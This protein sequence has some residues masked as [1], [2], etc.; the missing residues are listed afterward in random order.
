MTLVCNEFYWVSSILLTLSVLLEGLEVVAMLE[1]PTLGC[2][3]FAF[4]AGFSLKL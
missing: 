1:P 3:G 4:V 2:A